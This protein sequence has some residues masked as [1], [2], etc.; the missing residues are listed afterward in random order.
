VQLQA[1][2]IPI[3]LDGAAR[4]RPSVCD[5]NEDGTPDV[6][7]GAQDGKVHLYLGVP[8]PTT[9]LFAVCGGLVLLRRHAVP[10]RVSWIAE[11]GASTREIRRG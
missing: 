7:V 9:L 2:G 8:E 5:W 11:P 4:S 1:E 6:L 3:D 10:R